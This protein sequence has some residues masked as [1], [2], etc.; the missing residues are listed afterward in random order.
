MRYSKEFIFTIDKELNT[1]VHRIIKHSGGHNLQNVVV[2]TSRRKLFCKISFEK[3]SNGML[4][5]EKEG[6]E[7]IKK[8][9]AIKTPEIIGLYQNSYMSFLVLEYIEAMRPKPQDWRICGSQLAHLHN[10]ISSPTFGWSK[11]NYI[12]ALA[13]VNSLD[14][15]WSSFFGRYRLVPQI[16]LAL[17]TQKLSNSMIPSEDKIL[18]VLSN[19]LSCE[20]PSLLHGDLWS[21]NVLFDSQGIP[22]LIDPSL[23][24]GD[25][26]VDI[27]MTKLFGGFD[28]NF[29]LAYYDSGAIQKPN[30]ATIELYQLYY[31]LVHL[32]LFGKSY[33]ASVAELLKKYFH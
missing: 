28:P 17:S 1:Q 14:K 32:N 26:A 30:T 25:P 21:G 9:G 16:E 13:Q 2:I 3:T 11:D 15:N 20:K 8:S 19:L 29:Y 7:A 23:Y 6:L 5:S 22:W 10:T 33:Y 12:G 24:Y 18:G 31:L 27:A 4:Q